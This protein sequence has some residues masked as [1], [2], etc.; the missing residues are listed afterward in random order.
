MLQVG[1][2]MSSVGI[3][4]MATF[5]IED[6]VEAGYEHVGGDAGNQRLVDLLE[7]LAGRGGVKSLRDRL[8]HAAGGGHNQ[9]RG[10]PL[11]CC[12]AYYDPHSTLR[13]EMEVVEVSSH[14][15]GR[16]VEG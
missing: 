13:K 5:G 15:P 8:Q 9:R 1:Q 14:L 10:H 3:H 6:G 11:A 12:V 2:V 16:L 7:Y 4:K